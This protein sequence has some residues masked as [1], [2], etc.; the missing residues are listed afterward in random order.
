MSQSL[1]IAEVSHALMAALKVKSAVSSHALITAA[2][3]LI[4]AVLSR[5]AWQ[6]LMAV[7]T[8]TKDSTNDSH[9]LIAVSAETHA[10]MA[11]WP[12]LVASHTLMAAGTTTIDLQALMADAT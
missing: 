12:T 2:H 6:A 1:A 5:V 4:A 10:L 3:A 7:G 9:A 8:T 11:D